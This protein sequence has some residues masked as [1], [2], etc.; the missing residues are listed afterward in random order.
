MSI[1]KYNDYLEATILVILLYG[2]HTNSLFMNRKEFI[3]KGGSLVALTVMGL[4]SSCSDDDP[5]PS[6]GEELVIDLS[7]APFDALQN[8]GAWILHPDKNV[9]IVNFEGNIRAFTSIC[10]HSNC[11]RNW[12]F[13][14][15]QATC[16]CHGSKFDYAGKVISGP[17]NSDLANFAV[18]K[19][20]NTLT[21]N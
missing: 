2:R 1:L 5:A 10:T 12:V 17:A 3:K 18:S 14:T 19:D 4:S 20:G 13:G 7:Q 8:E 15:T 16:T 21:I 6:L 11:S 9:I